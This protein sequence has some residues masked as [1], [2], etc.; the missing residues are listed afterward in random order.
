M[1]RG[2]L[3]ALGRRVCCAGEA[4]FLCRLAPPAHTCHPG[5]VIPAAS[6]RDNGA[7]ETMGEKAPYKPGSTSTVPV[8]LFSLEVFQ[9]TYKLFFKKMVQK[10]FK[11][12]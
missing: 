8:F 2:Q 6:F 12:N 10:I 7:E 9:L 11:A 4:S 3:R 5:V 1:G